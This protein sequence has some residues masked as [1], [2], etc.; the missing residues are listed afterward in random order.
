VTR[1]VL[2]IPRASLAH[3]F[4]SDVWTWHATGMVSP[5]QDNEQLLRLDQPGE[6]VRAAGA[7]L[8][9]NLAD[10]GFVWLKS[11]GTLQRRDGPWIEQIHLQNRKWNRTGELIEFGSVVNARDRDLRKWR[12]ANPDLA[13]HDDDWVCGHQFGYIVGSLEHGDVDLSHPEQRLQRLGD[14]LAK[15]RRAAVPWFASLRDP[16]RLGQQVDNLSLSAHPSS[17]IEFAMSR[18]EYDQARQIVRRWLAISPAHPAR[19][20]AGRELAQRGEK[21]GVMNR[22]GEVGWTSTVLQLN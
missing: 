15:I 4:R 16:A 1:G 18:N 6:V 11:R 14:F 21:P 5:D 22:A 13:F 17:L 10:E 12:Q 3:W 2:S 9:A 19:F 8:A 20:A 7:W